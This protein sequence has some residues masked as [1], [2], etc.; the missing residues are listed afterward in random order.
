MKV[1]GTIYLSHDYDL[2]LWEAMLFDSFSKN[3][4]R[5]PIRIDLT[6]APKGQ[7]NRSG[8]KQKA[9]L[10]LTW[11]YQHGHMISEFEIFLNLNKFFAVISN[12]YVLEVLNRCFC[13]LYSFQLSLTRSKGKFYFPITITTNKGNDSKE[14]LPLSPIPP[15]LFA[16]ASWGG[17][18]LKMTPLPMTMMTTCPASSCDNRRTMNNRPQKRRRPRQDDHGNRKTTTTRGWWQR[19]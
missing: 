13:C 5:T 1:N 17:L 16:N 6:I 14:K 11:D 15:L 19:K 18:V 9:K 12:L 3:N 7:Q 10:T 8:S 4:F 2:V